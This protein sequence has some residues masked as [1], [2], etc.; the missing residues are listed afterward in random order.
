[1][2]AERSRPEWTLSIVQLIALMYKDQNVA[3]LQ[4]LLNLWFETSDMSES[5]EDN[6]SN[7]SPPVSVPYLIS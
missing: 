7:T 5:S 1:M 3:V 2:I 6:E 4:K